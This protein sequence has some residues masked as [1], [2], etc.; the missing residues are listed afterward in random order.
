M[1]RKE[2]GEATAA[3]V[4]YVLL[5]LPLFALVAC[6]WRQLDS[7]QGDMVL[8][9]MCQ[10]PPALVIINEG[11]T[12]TIFHFH[13]GEMV[14]LATQTS[15]Q[16]GCHPLVCAAAALLPFLN[17]LWLVICVNYFSISSIPHLLTQP[18]VSLVLICSHFVDYSKRMKAIQEG[19][20]SSETNARTQHLASALEPLGRRHERAM[21]KRIA[22][23]H[24]V[25]VNI[26]RHL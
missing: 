8:G 19:F 26:F 12:G 14:V 16:A 25:T 22:H 7:L 15:I 9:F 20:L 4:I 13:W 23:L 10:M 24:I 11:I 6:R 18:A 2:P 3:N 1:R 17:L 21:P 5:A